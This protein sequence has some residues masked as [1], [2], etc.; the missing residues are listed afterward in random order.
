M[1][2]DL[3]IS[4]PLKTKLAIG[5][6]SVSDPVNSYPHSIYSQAVYYCYPSIAL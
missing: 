4:T 5:C 1:A 2:A 6:D 3:E